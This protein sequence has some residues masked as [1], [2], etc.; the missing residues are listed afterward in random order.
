MRTQDPNENTA[1]QP[2]EDKPSPAAETAPELPPSPST[3]PAEVPAAPRPKSPAQARADE[4]QGAYAEFLVHRGESRVCDIAFAGAAPD[5]RMVWHCFSH[6]E[7]WETLGGAAKPRECP[8]VTP[9]PDE[10]MLG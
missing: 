10:T 1:E 8:A 4:L 3:P 6:K 9:K 2:A 7:T 5:D